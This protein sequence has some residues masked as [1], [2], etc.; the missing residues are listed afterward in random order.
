MNDEGE[1]SS[2]KNSKSIIIRYHTESLKLRKGVFTMKKLIV[3]FE[4]IFV[5]CVIGLMLRFFGVEKA[6]DW[7]TIFY[8]I[9]GSSFLISYLLRK[10]TNKKDTIGSN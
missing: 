10:S 1:K 2:I 7:G 4:I 6:K 3:F 5:L 9:G 8:I